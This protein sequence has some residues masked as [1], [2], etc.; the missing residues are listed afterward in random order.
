MSLDF[1]DPAAA[2]AAAPSPL[3]FL[4]A[5]ACGGVGLAL[6]RESGAPHGPA[7]GVEQALRL[8]QAEPLLRAVEQWLQS[9][10]D[11]APCPPPSPA[12]ADGWPGYRAVVRDPAL[13]PPGSVLHL[14]LG[15][16]LVPP[17]AALRAPA[18]AWASQPAQ[19]LLSQPPPQALQQLQPQALL[20]LPEA[21]GPE[22]VVQ[23]RDPAGRLPPCPA[24]L[25]LAAQ[26]LVVT[27][28]A[29]DGSLAPAEPPA[30]EAPALQVVLAQRV[31]V[32]L[33]H[34]LGWA[35]AGVPFHW[36]VPQPWAAELHLGG[37]VR[38]RGALLPLGQGCGLL[39]E[40][41]DA[42]LTA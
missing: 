21:F 7:S 30:G 5:T 16:L 29:H 2:P 13:A 27:A 40:A 32:P 8:A 33:D 42:A 18:L 1:P 38:A 24:R 4:G 20:W 15:A 17:P 28:G 39:V 12:G 25:E 22:W 9:P 41:E 3:H 14:P 36:P 35:R 31:Q 19:P 10:W 6:P 11:P 26:R 37:A 34:W 23:L